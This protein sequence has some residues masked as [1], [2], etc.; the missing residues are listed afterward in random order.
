[1]SSGR[2]TKDDI[3]GEANEILHILRTHGSQRAEEL[4]DRM[5]VPSRYLE[6]PLKLLKT[7]ERVTVAG[8]KRWTR[9]AAK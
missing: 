7:S 6:K 9:Y 1:M 2:R 4:A 5:R 3:A 8:E